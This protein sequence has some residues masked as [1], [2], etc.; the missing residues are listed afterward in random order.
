MKDKKTVVETKRMPIV[1]PIDLKSFSEGEDFP[2]EIQVLPVGKWNHPGYGPIVIDSS[3][4]KEFK[5]NFDD[6]IRNDIPIT[7]GH[8]V[9]GEEKPAVGWFKEL[10]DRGEKGLFATIEWTK[11]GKALLTERSYKYFSPEFYSE[12]EDPET[13][14]IFENVLVGGIITPDSKLYKNGSSETLNPFIIVFDCDEFTIRSPEE[15]PW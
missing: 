13:R 2:K 5:K 6:R 10:M 3:D 9:F 15:P 1:F 8:E 4:I 14:E 12:Y 7:E 11:E